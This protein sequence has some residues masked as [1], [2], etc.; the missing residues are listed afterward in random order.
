ML[1][2]TFFY[3][4]RK[5]NLMDALWYF[6][7]KWHWDFNEGVFFLR[8]TAPFSLNDFQT[9]KTEFLNRFLHLFSLFFWRLYC[10]QREF[11][12]L[13]AQMLS[14]LVELSSELFWKPE[15]TWW[16]QGL[17][18]H[19][20]P[21]CKAAVTLQTNWWNILHEMLVSCFSA[22]N[23]SQPTLEWSKMCST[24]ADIL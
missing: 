22:S 6:L 24:M 3:I 5:V 2:F 4:T 15:E 19:S 14:P 16:N 17:I 11:W 8:W 20:S 21:P 9:V 12:P 18:S 10:I 1:E 7:F 23:C 13:R